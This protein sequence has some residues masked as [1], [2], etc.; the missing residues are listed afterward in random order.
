M[1]RPWFID[2]VTIVSA[3]AGPGIMRGMLAPGPVLVKRAA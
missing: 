1:N 2:G 3:G